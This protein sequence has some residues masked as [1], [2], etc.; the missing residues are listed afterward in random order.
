MKTKFT[1]FLSAWIHLSITFTQAQQITGALSYHDLA[2]MF[3][4]YRYTGSARIQGLGNTQISLGGDISSAL[5][6]PAGLG[7]YNRSEF[8]IT[9]S[10]NVI[11]ADANYLGTSITTSLGKFN[12][13]NF[14]V[15]ICKVKDDSAPGSWRGGS[16]GISVSKTNEFNSKVQYQGMNPNNDILDYYVQ[17]ANNQNVDS[18]LLTGTTFGAFDTYLLSEFVDGY[19][20]GSDTTYIPFYDRT[21]FSEY[22]SDAY[23]TDQSEIITTSGSQNQINLSYGGNFSDKFYIGFTLGVPTV[24]YSILREYSELYPGLSGDIVDNMH[25]VEDLYTDGIG[26]NGTFGIIARPINQLTLGFSIITP[27]AFAMSESYYY[28]TDADY[29]TFDLDN[30]G[31]YFDANY[32]LIVNDQADFT[33]FY[34]VNATLD[35]HSYEEESQF[36]YTITTPMR[37]NGGLSYFFAKNGF[38]SADIEYVDYS[39]I[40]AKSDE[41]D[42]SST[43]QT[44][45]ELYKSAINYRLGAEWRMKSF[46]VRGGYEMRGNPYNTNEIDLP[47]NSFSGGFGFR[48]AKFFG[49][50]GIIYTTTE[51]KYAPYI[52]D[53][54]NDEAYLQTPVADISRTNLN[55][56][57]S[58]GIFF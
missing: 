18:D 24:K 11:S 41:G 38:I 32:D 12:I 17:D 29:F 4:D 30:Y 53:N 37:I 52:L 56:V 28:R 58:M 27:T 19:I 54:P 33:S 44:I 47:S 26:I 51:N 20:N 31:D 3:S 9:P 57:L 39:N 34:E 15:V 55:V 48:S 16:F 40:K 25:L 49:D 6:N 35:Q 36:N 5:S 1:L 2:F 7:F 23:P 50:L 43:N 42:L 21:F 14:G 10:Y 22:P 13:D 45:G 8:S 46:R